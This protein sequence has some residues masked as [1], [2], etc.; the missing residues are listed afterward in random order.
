MN[1]FSF[2]FRTGLIAGGYRCTSASTTIDR[3]I[4]GVWAER[5]IGCALIA[6]GILGV[7]AALNKRVSPP[8]SARNPPLLPALPLA[9]AN[10]QEDSCPYDRSSE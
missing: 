3:A 6:F 5:C 4:V 10:Q 9:G 8:P 2:V 1:R 7:R